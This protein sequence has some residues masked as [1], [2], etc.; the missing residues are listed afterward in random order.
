MDGQFAVVNHV[1]HI[2]SDEHGGTLRSLVVCH[3]GSNGQFGA[4]SGS[5]RNHNQRQGASGNRQELQQ[6]GFHRQMWH[7]HA[8]GNHL[9]TI[10]HTSAT[11]GDDALRMVLYRQLAPRLNDSYVRFRMD[12]IIDGVAYVSRFQRIGNRFRV[13]QTAQRTVRNQ[14]HMFVSRLMA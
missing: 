10:H 11:K 14:Q 2:E 5:G 6:Q 1:C 12:I 7:L 4:C 8:G 3:H 13:S 9:A